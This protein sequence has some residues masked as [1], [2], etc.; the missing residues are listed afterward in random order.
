MTNTRSRKYQRGKRSIS[1]I[2]GRSKLKER[3]NERHYKESRSFGNAKSRHN[4]KLVFLSQFPT[5]LA[6]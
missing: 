5:V 3:T 4:K 6:L 1:L 2:Q